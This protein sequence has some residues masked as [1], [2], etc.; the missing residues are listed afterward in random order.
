MFAVLVDVHR[1]YTMTYCSGADR[2]CCPIPAWPCDVLTTRSSDGC[3][4]ASE[5]QEPLI[6]AACEEAGDARTANG[7]PD[8]DPA[9]K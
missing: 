8:Q 5:M 2:D 7:R 1:G 4:D 6:Q 9:A 3:L